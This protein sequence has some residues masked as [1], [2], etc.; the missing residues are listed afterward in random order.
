[1][2]Y[3]AIA[4]SHWTAF[5]V[6]ASFVS[7]F[8]NT[9]VFLAGGVVLLLTTHCLPIAQSAQFVTLQNS[10]LSIPATSVAAAA[11]PG[12]TNL[13]G[14]NLML[15]AVAPG[16]QE[17]GRASLVNASQWIR[18][19]NGGLA[20]SQNT[21][22]G[23]AIRNDGSVVVAG[24]SY[25]PGTDYDFAT[26]SY[27]ADGTAL[28]TNRYDGPGH[29]ADFA[30]LITANPSGDVWVVG[31]SMREAINW[32]LTDVAIIRY[33]SNGVPLWTNRYSSFETNGAYPLGLAADSAGN[34]YVAQTGT[35]WRSSVGSPIEDSITKYDALGNVVWTRHYLRTAPDSGQGLHDLGPMAL[36]DAGNLFVGGSSGMEYYTSGSSIVKFASDG[37]ALWTNYHSFGLMAGINLLSVDRQGNVIATGEAFHLSTNSYVILKCLKDGASLWTNVL[38]GPRYDGGNVPRTLPDPFGNVLLV[39]GRPGASPGRYQ[40]LKIGSNGIPLWTNQHADFGV[41]NSLIQDAA[42]DTA[43]NL[44][45]AGA[46][47]TPNGGHLDYVTIKYSVD[48]RPLWTNLFN[49]G[50]NLDD[51]P[52]ALSVDGA[53]NVY[54]AGTSESQAGQQ[55]FATIKYAAVLFYY[56]PKD[57]AGSDAITCIVTDA[58]GNYATGSVEILVAR[59]AFQFNLSPGVATSTPAGI[60]LQLQGG[61]G[62]NAVVLEAS[63][64]LSSWKRILTNAPDHGAVHFSVPYDPS[65]P[66]QFYRALQEQ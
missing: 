47:P 46:A 19:Y 22:L 21:P 60:Q 12:P 10:T 29:G 37:T 1:M 52:F 56:P 13:V 57:F 35:Y 25:S 28:W 30:R 38:A 65:Q 34:V 63:Q 50:A 5:L 59:G 16:T 17:G 45:L 27:A 31:E 44:Y 32:E 24:Y 43:G 41:T 55:D 64:D 49:G 11:V 62:T 2:R 26:V 61:A 8:M 23:M 54:V 33:G 66:R 36:D 7:G 15:S 4:K 51:V 48:G 40:I 20:S 6:Y 39:G 9:R 58:S 18:R 53:G 14:S 42:V 3:R